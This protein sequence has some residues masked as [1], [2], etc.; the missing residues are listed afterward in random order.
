VSN[1]REYAENPVDLAIREAQQ[2]GEFDNLPGAGK[3]LQLSSPND[4]DWWIKGLI[5]REQ[6]DMT[7]A[8]P[9]GIALRREVE[10]LPETL[11]DVPT[12]TAAREIVEDLNRRVLEDRRRLTLGPTIL[13]PTVDVDEAIAMWRAD[14]EA[15]FGTPAR[16]SP[17]PAESTAP[18]EPRSRPWWKRYFGRR[19]RMS[20]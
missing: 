13:A 9:P 8:L 4:P 16:T 20:D 15:R 10:R 3:P 18:A 19:D 1:V 17:E 2:R 14:R 6:L 5:Q 12:E 7:A 11:A